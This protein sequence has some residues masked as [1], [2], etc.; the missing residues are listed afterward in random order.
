LDVVEAQASVAGVLAVAEAQVV[1][2]PWVLALVAKAV[3][4][5]MNTGYVSKGAYIYKSSTF[6]GFRGTKQPEISVTKLSS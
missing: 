4:K 6:I 3:A 2:V 5:A 1:V